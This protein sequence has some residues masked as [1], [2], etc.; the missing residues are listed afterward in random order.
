MAMDCIGSNDVIPLC[1]ELTPHQWIEGNG[2]LYD[3]CLVIW[4]ENW[5]HVQY[6]LSH[7]VKALSE[8]SQ[9]THAH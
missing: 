5:K 7:N 4:E 2:V 9:L 3:W 8:N 6:N 1:R